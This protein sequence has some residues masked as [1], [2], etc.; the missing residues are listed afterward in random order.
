M[1]FRVKKD[2]KTLYSEE[3]FELGIYQ[4]KLQDRSI[5]EIEYKT[6]NSSDL[7]VNENK[8]N[9]EIEG[10]NFKIKF[11]KINGKLKAGFL[12]RGDNKKSSKIKFLQTYDR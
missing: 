5:K 7:I 2:S 12:M 4:F 9:V 6:N 11:S 1:N 3:N 10:Y 8:L